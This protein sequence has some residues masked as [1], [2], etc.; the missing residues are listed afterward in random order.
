MDD[1]G[2]VYFRTI[3]EYVLCKSVLN[4][5]HEVTLDSLLDMSL[6]TEM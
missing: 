1:A 2:N 3:I 5:V 6:D 4:T